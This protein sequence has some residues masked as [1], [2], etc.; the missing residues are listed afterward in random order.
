MGALIKT[1][2]AAWTEP[3]LIASGWYPRGVST[4]EA[5]LRYYATQFPLV[6]ND[7]TYYA[8]PAERQARLWSERTPEGFTMNVKAFASL[9]AHYTDPRRLPRDV[10]DALPPEVREKPRVYPKDLGEERVDEIARRF[11]SALEPLRTSGRLGLLLFQYP[12]WITASPEGRAQLLRARRWFPE[13]RIAIEFRNA[14][15]MSSP[16]R[17]AETL[18]FLRDLGVVYTCVDEPQGF[19]SSVPPV[20]EATS[21]VALVRLHGRRAETWNKQSNGARERFRYQYS[22]AEL[23]GWVPKIHGLAER[24]REVHVILNNCYRNYATTNARQI[25][26][27]LEEA[28]EAVPRAAA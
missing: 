19:P 12:V 15:W 27:L 2:I 24:T 20:A 11:R 13:H 14:T 28:G 18:A 26:E 4:A 1:G 23:S 22:E 10:R 5:R 21:D 25:A 7:G 17:Q 9:T 8:L 3:T 16:Q 6:E